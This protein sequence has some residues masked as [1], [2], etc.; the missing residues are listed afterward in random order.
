MKLIS[1]IVRAA[2][3]DATVYEDVEADRSAMRQA[4]VAVVLSSIATGIG[5]MN[6]DPFHIILGIVAALVSWY[7]WAYMIY[8]VGAKL[9]PEADTEADHGQLLRTLGFA[10]APGLFRGFGQVPIVGEAIFLGA[11]VWML[12]ATVVA[13]RQAL[14]YTS[15]PR[16]IA[17]CIIGWIAYGVVLSTLLILFS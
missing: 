5:G 3:L 7:A 14:D 9:F 16:A 13:A 12:A 8:I 15:M 11:S 1:R 6:P 4:T 2:K 17:V 10:S